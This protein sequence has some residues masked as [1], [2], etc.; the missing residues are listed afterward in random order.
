MEKRKTTAMRSREPEQRREEAPDLP[1]SDMAD[2]DTSIALDAEEN[3]KE[4]AEKEGKILTAVYPIL[5]L[6]HQY[7]VGEELPANDPAMTAAWI[8]AGTA[9]W[10]QVPASDTMEAKNGH[11][12]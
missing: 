7:R 2:E 11:D 5:Y 6:A 4:S 12:I 3:G 9:V 8:A 1:G 10:S